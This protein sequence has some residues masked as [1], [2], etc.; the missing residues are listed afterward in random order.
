LSTD[1]EHQRHS[2]VKIS[3]MIEMRLG[4]FAVAVAGI[5]AMLWIAFAG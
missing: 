3:A 2:R 1:I 5:F 4:C